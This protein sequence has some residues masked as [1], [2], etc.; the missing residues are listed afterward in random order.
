MCWPFSLEPHGPQ[1]LQYKHFVRPHRGS[2]CLARPGATLSAVGCRQAGPRGA[3]RSK[4][5]AALLAA[6]SVST[7]LL[8]EYQVQLDLLPDFERNFGV[9]VVL[10]QRLLL[11]SGREG[12]DRIST[13]GGRS[14]SYGLRVRGYG[15]R[16]KSKESLGQGEFQIRAL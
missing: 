13:E 7:P 12:V 16:I 11:S 2:A 10:Y 3:F 15:L 8:S 6:F 5:K 4:E 9:E 1:Y 14:A